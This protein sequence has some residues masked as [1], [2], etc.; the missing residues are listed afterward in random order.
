Y[1]RNG[2]KGI[3]VPSSLQ[4]RD[5]LLLDAEYYG[6]PEL[7][8]RLRTANHY[9]L[10]GGL[11]H[12]AALFEVQDPDNFEVSFAGRARDENSGNDWSDLY[13]GIQNTP[14][15]FIGIVP[16]EASLSEE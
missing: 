8:A 4:D 11:R 5:A 13:L 9:A 14:G 2:S 1:L 7:V 16:A 10:V 12:A 6:L 3:I 15:V